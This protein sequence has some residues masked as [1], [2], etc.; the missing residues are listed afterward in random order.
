M[1]LSSLFKNSL[2]IQPMKTFFACLLLLPFGLLAQQEAATWYF[3][4]NAGM[5]FNDFSVTALTDG[6]V[7]YKEGISCISDCRGNLLFYTDATTVWNSNHAIMTNGGNLNGH[8][9]AT[10]GALIVPY[11]GNCNLY[12][13]FTVDGKEHGFANGLQYHLIDMSLQNGMG[14]VVSK[15]NI[16]YANAAEKQ[17]AVR[18]RNGKDYWLVTHLMYSDQFYAYL[19]TDAGINPVPVITSCGSPFSNTFDGLG[20]MKISSDGKRLAYV[21]L[22]NKRAEIFDFN[23][24][25]GT[26]SNPVTVPASSFTNDGGLYGCE[27]SPDGNKLYVSNHTLD[28]INK[29]GSLYQ[30]DLLAGNA[31]DIINSNT[32]VGSNAP[33]CDLRGMQLGPD[34]KIYVTR[35]LAKVLG[36][37]TSPNAAGTA[38]NYTDLGQTLNGKV[39]G[40]TLPNFVSSIFREDQPENLKAA[41]ENGMVCI[42][43]KTNF[44]DLSKGEPAAWNWNFGDSTVSELQNP[45]HVYEV[46][47]IYKVTLI[48]SRECCT[49]TTFQLIEANDCFYSVYAPNAF[50]PNG[51]GFNDAFLISG[52]GIRSIQLSV[53][54]RW[55]E[56][57]F[58][59]SEPAHGWD[60]SFNRKP[61]PS[62]MYYYVLKTEFKNGEEKNE[63]GSLMLIR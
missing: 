42:N 47:G 27:F 4:E 58:H 25:T 30:L 32:L 44:T 36:V 54:N 3:G 41:F 61:A 50:S 33:V 19:I 48:V 16:L 20:Q 52:S 1:E 37:I 31:N 35:S 21:T 39:C 63:N 26:V 29:S 55:G 43:K 49:D 51:D 12:Y 22:V 15:N 5:K 46:P 60:G 11:P 28:Y 2:A 14:E 56:K 62:G 40:W 17:A 57:V 34:G 59:S 53:Y 13:L 45:V 24:A 23:D 8:Y 38:C 10:Q 7:K 9:S 6:N 18:H